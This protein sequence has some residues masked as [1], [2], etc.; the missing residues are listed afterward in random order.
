MAKATEQLQANLDRIF[1]PINQAIDDDFKLSLADRDRRERLAD[2][3]RR[4]KRVDKKAEAALARQE[5]RDLLRIAIENGVEI[6]DNATNNQIVKLIK[7]R[8]ESIANNALKQTKSLYEGDRRRIEARR[9]ELESKR[10]SIINESLTPLQKAQILKSILSLPEYDKSIRKESRKK[11]DELMKK[12]LMDPR[13]TDSDVDTLVR[14]IY[15]D[16][17]SNTNLFWY[18]KGGEKIAD[19][20]NQS[21]NGLVG[22]QLMA[23]K[24][25]G[26]AEWQEQMKELSRESQTIERGRADA[27]KGIIS[28]YGRWLSDST[29]A[30]L[31]NES[32]P[33][34]PAA[35][36]VPDSVRSKIKQAGESAATPPAETAPVNPGPTI[37]QTMEREGVVGVVKRADP[38]KIPLV[39]P[40]IAGLASFFPGTAQNAV[41]AD[42]LKAIPAVAK[43]LMFGNPT[44]VPPTTQEIDAFRNEAHARRE[45]NRFIGVIGKIPTSAETATQTIVSRIQEKGE[46]SPYPMTPTMIF[47]VIQMATAKHGADPKKFHEFQ[48]KVQS[49]DKASIALWNQYVEDVQQSESGEP[50]AP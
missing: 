46:E 12:D 35:T 29:M 37:G 48:M 15:S 11:V 6:P 28:Q 8:N 44:T 27:L 19:S 3:D 24:S 2:E 34:T 7:E 50:V 5:K 22:E 42:G 30:E 47:K 20:F 4:E 32:Q 49:G 36:V 14:G 41:V 9:T 18:D 43:D 23:S 25:A 1:S 26:Y 16:I 38:T 21:Y 39:G 17:K 33:G 10:E 13:T 40:S 45:R 31:S